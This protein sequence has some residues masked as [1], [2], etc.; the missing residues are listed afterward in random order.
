MEKDGQFQRIHLSQFKD[1]SILFADI[2]GF[3][4]MA[5]KNTAEC[6]VQTLHNLFAQFDV[7]ANS[8]NCYRIKLLGDCYYCVSGIK[9][10]NS[11][12]RKQDHAHNSV[13]MAMEM[14]GALE[15]VREFNYDVDDLDMRIGVHTGTRWFWGEWA[16]MVG[17][18][19]KWP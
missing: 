10:G 2:A 1:V 15:L 13:L 12:G 5:S 7:L 14:I 9:S 17:N 6:V 18:G 4:S 8:N 3:T 11:L 19:V 16:G